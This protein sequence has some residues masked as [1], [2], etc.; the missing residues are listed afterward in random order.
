MKLLL[1][2]TCLFTISTLTSQTVSTI[3]EG[4]FTDGLGIDSQGIIYGSDFGGTNVYKYDPSTELVSTFATGFTNPN[5]IGVSSSDEVYICEAGGGTIH[6]FDVDGNVL[7]T[8]TGLNNPTG[9]QYDV[10]NDIIYWVSY[11]ES[12][13]YELDPVTGTSTQIYIGAPLNGPSGIAFVGDD[14]F[15]SNFND[16]RI[17]RLEDDDSLTEIAQLPSIGPPNTDFCGFLASKDSQLIATHIGG[18]RIFRI[19]PL[20]GQFEVIAGSTQGTADGDIT[21]ATFFQPN[22][23]VGDNINDRIYITDAAP[24]NLRIIDGITLSATDL[25]NPFSLQFL[26]NPTKDLLFI[27]GKSKISDAYQLNVYNVQGKL[28]HQE[29]SIAREGEI[30]HSVSTASWPV[31]TYIVKVSW[32]NGSISKKISKK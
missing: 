21:E 11:N 30:N 20:N 6:K 7:E 24:N 5:G 32:Q 4:N 22:G 28:I 16:R 25:E 14:V 2:V 23:I 1:Y 3:T 12:S 15:I 29:D 9:V 13:L 17:F 19:N 27:K 31:G 18:H 10:L 8:F 26:P